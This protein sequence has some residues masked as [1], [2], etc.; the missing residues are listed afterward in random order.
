MLLSIDMKKPTVKKIAQANPQFRMLDY[1]E[2]NFASRTRTHTHDLGRR[3]KPE[4]RG[5][6]DR[7][8]QHIGRVML[9]SKLDVTARIPASADDLYISL[10]DT[11]QLVAA[12]RIMQT[13]L[14][15]TL[16]SILKLV[17]FTGKKDDIHPMFRSMYFFRAQG[18]KNVRLGA[19]VNADDIAINRGELNTTLGSI[20][21]IPSDRREKPTKATITIARFSQSL[22]NDVANQILDTKGIEDFPRKKETLPFGGVE[23][24]DLTAMRQRIIRPDP[25]FIPG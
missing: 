21:G 7:L 10:P 19:E 24:I 13:G 4:N 3:L 18:Q 6:W 12:Q 25:D 5:P 14:P 17:P 1:V 9:A 11:E 8:L 2:P 23:V 16:D 22:P 15:N 20:Q